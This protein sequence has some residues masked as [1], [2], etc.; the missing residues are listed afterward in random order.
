MATLRQLR[1]G[2]G[3]T[4]AKLEQ[5]SGLARKTI[6]SAERGGA[7]QADTAKALADA[8]GKGYGKEIQSWE[9]EKLVIR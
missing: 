1:L 9:I 6:T 7:V 8:L 3:W 2:L 4:I 5:E